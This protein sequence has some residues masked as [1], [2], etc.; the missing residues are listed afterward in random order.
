MIERSGIEGQKVITPPLWNE[1]PC[2]N[3]NCISNFENFM[4]SK[5]LKQTSK[6]SER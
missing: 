6:Y 4:A 3:E 1:T 5:T 2:D